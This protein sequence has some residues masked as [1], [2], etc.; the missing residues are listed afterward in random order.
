MPHQSSKL[1]EGA[2][3]GDLK[4]LVLP[5][6]TVDEF[7]SKMGDDADICVLA[8]TVMG[9]EPGTDLVNFIE[10]GYDWVL[11]A[12]LSSG[13]LS[14]GNYLVFVEIERSKKIPEQIIQLLEDM[15]NLTEQKIEEWSL[16]YHKDGRKHPLDPASIAQAI[17]LTKE[18]YNAK[19]GEEAEVKESLDR[20][21][22]LAR[23][24]VNTKA[25]VNEYTELLRTIAG[26][27]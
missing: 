9:K 18:K 11:D 5:V 22:S 26:I 21:R 6:L 1:N 23:V 7:R 24:K 4:R 20:F 17:P 2:E 15:M 14:D 27:R 10:K 16:I 19:V 13:E 25:P 3:Y 8:F 12:D